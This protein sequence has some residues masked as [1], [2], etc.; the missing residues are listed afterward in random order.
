MTTDPTVAIPG[1]LAGTWQADAARSEIA[2]SIRQVTAR[3][4]G[5]FTG[6]HVTIVTRADPQDSSVA[7]TIDLASIDTGNRLRNRHLRFADYLGARTNPTMSYRSTGIRRTEAGWL[8][9][10]D[11]TLHGGTRQVPLTVEVPGFGGRRARFAATA[12]VSR[13]DFGIHVTGQ[14]GGVLIADQVSIS[15]VIE[16]VLVDGGRAGHD[17]PH[18]QPRP[19][20]LG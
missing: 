6:C 12:T 14:T 20:G 11:L 13:R 8:V 5:R 16:A 1:Y 4:R 9:D 10:G 3:V 17:V 7:A 19:A 2:F 15:L 18:D